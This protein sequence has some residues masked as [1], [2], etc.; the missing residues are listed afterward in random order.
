MH[1]DCSHFTAANQRQQS[2]ECRPIQVRAGLAMIVEALIEN[3]KRFRF[4]KSHAD[5]ALD[6]ARREIAPGLGGLASVNG[7]EAAAYPIYLGQ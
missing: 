4:S 7:A 3:L 2:L 6:I 1:D 5:F